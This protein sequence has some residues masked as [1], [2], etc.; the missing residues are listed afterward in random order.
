M[1]NLFNQSYFYLPTARKVGMGAIVAASIILLPIAI[2]NPFSTSSTFNIISFV[3]VILLLWALIILAPSYL[4]KTHSL[5][6]V[7]WLILLLLLT[8]F[9]SILNINVDDFADRI[10]KV[11]NMS[12]SKKELLYYLGVGMGG[13]VAT[14]G[15]SAVSLISDAQREKNKWDGMKS[16]TQNITS[17][18]SLTRIA[19][20]HEFYH[21]AQDHEDIDFRKSICD[22]L[23]ACWC[24]IPESERIARTT[25]E[26]Q[27]LSNIIIKFKDEMK[28]ICS[29]V[30]KDKLK[31]PSNDNYL[32][33]LCP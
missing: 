9:I 16:A 32:M 1:K 28:I 7:L 21:L 6:C 24:K 2:F 25:Y 27:M 23:C 26:S 10:K 30:D 12:I 13:M 3:L 14:I 17:I 31:K 19:A 4:A 8:L 5:L 18:W 15:A 33:N 20:Y 29:L 22:I 11:L